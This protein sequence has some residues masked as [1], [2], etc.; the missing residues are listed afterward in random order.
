MQSNIHHI[1]SLLYIY[2]KNMHTYIW[3][4]WNMH[5]RIYISWCVGNVSPRWIPTKRENSD[6]VWVEVLATS[7]RQLRPYTFLSVLFKLFKYRHVLFV[8]FECQQNFSGW[9]YFETSSF[10]SSYISIFL[11]HN[12]CFQINK[13][14]TNSINY[15]V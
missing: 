2:L 14:S 8:I 5:M 6:Y 4:K 13:S 7:K 15:N 12:R 1:F 9:L 3:A 11:D 10:S